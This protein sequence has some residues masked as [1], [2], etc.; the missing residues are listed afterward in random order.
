MRFIYF[1]GMNLFSSTLLKWYG[2]NKRELPWRETRDPY[3]IWVSEIILQQTRVAQGMDY[4]LRFIER[5]PDLKSLAGAEEDEVLR[6]WQGLGYYS[7][8]RNMLDAARSVGEFPKDYEG[9]RK[10]KGVGEYTAA[11]IC[12]FAYGMP[13]AVVDG[14]VYRVLSRYF[15]IDE[16]IDTGKGRK[17]FQMLAQELLPEKHGAEYNQAVM[18]FGAMQCVPAAPD[19][20]KCPLAEGC[21]A[22]REGK[23]SELPVKSKRIKVTRRFFNYLLI[24]NGGQIYIERR[25]KGDIWQGMYQLPL[26]ETEREMRQE[27]FV[28][29]KRVKEL[30]GECS[31]LLQPVRI[32]VKHVLSHQ[33]LSA[34][35]YRIEISHETPLLEKE[36]LKVGWNDLDRY[37]LPKLLLR[38]LERE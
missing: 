26:V 17:T 30:V 36:Y 1:C 11:A 3:K 8:A 2:V 24:E 12:S 32:G 10:M 31:A 28:K 20:M 29:L 38:L 14:N 22:F 15:G 35:L 5:F 23:T 19:C 37:A 25:G 13:Y 18:D 4:Y 27:E 33:Q 21:R 6:M 7:R 16:P 34:S 9:V